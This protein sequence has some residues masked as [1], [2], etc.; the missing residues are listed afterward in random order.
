MGSKTLQK[1]WKAYVKQLEQT[2][3]KIPAMEALRPFMG[4]RGG[5]LKRQTRSK[6]Q[7]EA[8]KAAA[9]G[10]KETLGRK[11]SADAIKAAQKKAK[12]EQQKKTAGKNAAT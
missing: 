2:N 3:I 10:V 7:K 6:K 1:Q 11:T 5:V 12:F 8:F 4:A 9:A